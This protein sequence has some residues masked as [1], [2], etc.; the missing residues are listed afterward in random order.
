MSDFLDSTIIT[1]LDHKD[2]YRNLWPFFSLTMPPGSRFH[3][4]DLDFFEKYKLKFG[5][6]V[7]SD[8]GRYSVVLLHRDNYVSPPPLLLQ[9]LGPTTTRHAPYAFLTIESTNVNPIKT[10]LKNKDFSLSIV[11]NLHDISLMDEHNRIYDIKYRHLSRLSFTNTGTSNL[12][13]A[14]EELLAPNECMRAS[15][16]RSWQARPGSQTPP[17]PYSRGSR[18]QRHPL[19]HTFTGEQRLLSGPNQAL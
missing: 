15:Y 1:M 11:V 4:F 13:L 3:T 8:A 2:R 5:I 18:D 12:D 7:F 10:F 19:P 6:D 9:A 14:E 17:P 16:N